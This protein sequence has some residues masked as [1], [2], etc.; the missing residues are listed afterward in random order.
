MWHRCRR[1]GLALLVGAR[2]FR[3]G[4]DGAIHRFQARWGFSGTGATFSI[5][6]PE[7]VSNLQGDEF[8]QCKRWHLARRRFF[9]PPA[10]ARMMHLKLLRAS[11]FDVGMLAFSSGPWDP[12]REERGTS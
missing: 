12:A 9:A 5:V 11:R 1:S 3:V 6:R 10:L 8:E 7:R 2:A 4:E